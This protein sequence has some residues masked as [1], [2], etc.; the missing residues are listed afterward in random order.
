M[1][2]EQDGVESSGKNNFYVTTMQLYNNLPLAR[3]RRSKRD[4]QGKSAAFL[5]LKELKGQKNKVSVDEV[6]NVYE[7]VDEREYSK[8][9]QQRQ[10]DDWIIDDGQTFIRQPVNKTTKIF[11]IIPDGCGYVEDGREVFDDDL[12]DDNVAQA[13]KNMK[14]K[15]KKSSNKGL[16]GKSSNIK[17]MLINMPTKSKEVNKVNESL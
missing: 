12:D 2:D 9:V 17:N 11:F 14:L 6:E 16:P 5:R 1:A 4:S 15:G 10:E 8:R 3:N 13:S 7:E